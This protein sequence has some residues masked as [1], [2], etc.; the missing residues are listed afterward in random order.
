[1]SLFGHVEGVVNEVFESH[2]I[3][4]VEKGDSLSARAGNIALE[5]AKH[6]PVPP[7]D[8][9]LGK[10]LRDVV[11]HPGITKAVRGRE[12]DAVINECTVYEF[13]DLATVESL[14]SKLTDWLDA[15]CS[16]FDVH[17]FPG[18][19]EID[20]LVHGIS[21]ISGLT[22][23]TPFRSRTGRSI[24]PLQLETKILPE[25]ENIDPP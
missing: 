2:S 6:G 5:A 9:K 22:R 8:F 17:R 1:V 12:R 15:V 20:R 16:A 18:E 10:Y 19:N 7:L 11:A 24:D 21:D 13:L 25:D 4:R 14:E 23:V 3:P